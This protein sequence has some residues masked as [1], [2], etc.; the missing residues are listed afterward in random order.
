M[1]HTLFGRAKSIAGAAFI[2]LGVFVLYGN[3]GQAASRLSHPF[4]TSGNALGT[5]PSIILAAFQVLQ[6]CAFNHQHLLVYLFR[7]GLITFWPL[8]LVI[9]GTTLSRDAFP[10]DVGS[11]TKKDRELVDLTTRRSTSK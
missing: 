11:I 1:Q 2:G 10:G 8:L 9:A 3:L 5:L 7:R 4:G 6:A